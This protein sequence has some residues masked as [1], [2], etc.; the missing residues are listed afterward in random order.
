MP[1]RR[2]AGPWTHWALCPVLLE[3]LLHMARTMTL[4]QLIRSLR[5][6]DVITVGER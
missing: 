3:P 6:G 4:W 2:A 1:L 5:I